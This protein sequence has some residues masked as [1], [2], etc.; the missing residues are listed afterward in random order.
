MI[1]KGAVALA[2]TAVTGVLFWVAAA[3][4]SADDATAT[5]P[6]LNE[7]WYVTAQCA[8]PTG[9]GAAGSSAPATPYPDGTLHVGIAAGTETDRTYLNLDLGSLPA[10]AL[11]TGGTLTVPLDTD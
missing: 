9:C 4:V 1:R 2:A 3:P 10:G 11:L 5:V 8:L 7:A 6:T